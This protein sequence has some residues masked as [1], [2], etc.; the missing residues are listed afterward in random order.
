MEDLRK[1]YEKLLKVHDKLV[2]DTKKEREELF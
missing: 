2:E 1:K